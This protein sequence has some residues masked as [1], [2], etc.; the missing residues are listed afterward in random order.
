MR[1]SIIIPTLN[2]AQGIEECL[3]ALQPLRQQNCEIIV[4]DGGSSDATAT[5]AKPLVDSFISTPKGRSRQMNAGA[6]QAQNNILLFLHADTF[7]PENGLNLIHAGLDV[8]FD[9]GHFDIR[10]TGKHP[11]L[12]IIA[13]MMN[14][15]SKLS[16][17][18]TGDQALFVRKPIFDR[19]GQFPDI[20]L[21]E[22]IAL[23]K[24][25]KQL[26]KPFCI[27]VKVTSSGRR[28]EQFGVYRTIL[29]MWWLRAGFYCHISPTLLAHL[30]S[31]GQFW[32]H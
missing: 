18:A 11:M 17:I 21:M 19:I 15:R 8:G 14:L 12:T 26:G 27:T 5:V 30:Y 22:D 6:D 28:W 32:K 23:S 7:L 10:L 4:A 1:I 29:L 16:G 31:R 13:V 2:E 20:T 9:W 24:Q 25:L 3:L